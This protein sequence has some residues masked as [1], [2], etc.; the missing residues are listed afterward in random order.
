M[1]EKRVDL[2]IL[3]DGHHYTI[4]SLKIVET[5]NGSKYLIP[6]QQHNGDHMAF[7]PGKFH[8]KYQKEKK[9]IDI[10]PDD[11]PTMMSR[12]VEEIKS[13]QK[14]LEEL[15]QILLN[16]KLEYLKI[17]LRFLLLDRLR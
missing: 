9:Y 10:D 2:C 11:F 14:K 17:L 7:H 6:T 16:L 15:K 3:A 12:S 5:R 4:P 1:T 8:Y 13:I